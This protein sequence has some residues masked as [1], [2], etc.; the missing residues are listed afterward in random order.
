MGSHAVGAP[1]R[2][3]VAIYFSGI[4]IVEAYNGAHATDVVGVFGS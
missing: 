2:E 3:S 4:A 1:K